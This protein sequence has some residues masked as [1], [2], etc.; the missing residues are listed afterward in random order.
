MADNSVSIN[1]RL[2]GGARTGSF[3][4]AA[5]DDM[6]WIVDATLVVDS[7]R[8]MVDGG[9][10][11]VDVMDGGWWKVDRVGWMSVSRRCG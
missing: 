9:L 7:G 11:M 6:R 3:D 5:V 1:Q 10:W 4:S 2:L 8:W